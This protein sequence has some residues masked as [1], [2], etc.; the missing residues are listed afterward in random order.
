MPISH[1]I[2]TDKIIVLVWEITETLEELNVLAKNINTS[3]YSSKKRKKEH[4][5]TRLLINK[6]CPNRSI[7]YNEHGAPELDDSNNISISH[8]KELVTVI[9][10]QQKVGIDI[11]KISGKALRI[12]SK[13]ISKNNKQLLTSEKATLIWCAKEAIYKLHQKGNIDFI[14]DIKITDFEIE[15]KGILNAKFKSEILI[16]NYQKIHNHYLV[17]VCK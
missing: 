13:F 10:S 5:T 1:K 8:S 4:L 2:E 15:E 14:K 9:V 7:I 17:Y 12:S 6:I 3:H 16:L 11:E